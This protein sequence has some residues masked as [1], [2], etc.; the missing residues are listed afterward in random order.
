MGGGGVKHSFHCNPATQLKSTMLNLHDQPS[1][2]VGGG[3]W[4]GGVKHSFH[5]NPATQL[6]STM[7]NLHD[8]PSH[9]VGGGGWWGGCQ[10]FFSLQSC[11][12]IKIN[13]AESS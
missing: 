8:Q 11:N 9:I 5:C 10:T 13:N 3:G 1:H 2:I 12:P 4:W 6:K 7:L